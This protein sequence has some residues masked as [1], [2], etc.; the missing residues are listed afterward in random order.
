MRVEVRWS[1]C[2]RRDEGSGSPFRNGLNRL[3]VVVGIVRIET[4]KESPDF[5]PVPETLRLR[6]GANQ[7]PPA[8]GI[9]SLIVGGFLLT[10]TSVPSVNRP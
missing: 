1:T 9:Y 6:P 5:A 8:R 4:R 10:E 2:P 3:A 7:T